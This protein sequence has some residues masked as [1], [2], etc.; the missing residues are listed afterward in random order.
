[1]TFGDV[2]LFILIGFCV[3][4]IA[5]FG[6]FVVASL[7]TAGVFL[8]RFISRKVPELWERIP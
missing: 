4:A 3:I 8:A 7:I 1:M 6:A 2:L 5:L